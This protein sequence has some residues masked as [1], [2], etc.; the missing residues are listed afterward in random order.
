MRRLILAMAVVVSACDGGSA[1]KAVDEPAYVRAHDIH[2]LMTAVVEPQANVFWNS[3]GTINDAS[4]EH[5][6]TPTTDQGWLAA[7]SAAAT[8]AEMGNLLLTPQFADG[9]G[10]DW[11]QFSKSLV[12]IGM[13]AEKAAADRDSDAVMESG[14]TMYKV[15]TAC[16]EAYVPLS[17]EAQKA[18]GGKTP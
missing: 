14:A 4:G 18:Q 13:I 3:S 12:E 5:D 10:E 1:G 11:K 8:V 7:R 6:L 2:Q 16:H 9:R 15:C 17:G